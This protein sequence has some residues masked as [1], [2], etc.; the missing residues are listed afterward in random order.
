M[1]FAALLNLAYTARTALGV[2]P[3]LRAHV[4]GHHRRFAR[5]WA[6]M[7]GLAGRGLSDYRACREATAAAV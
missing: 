2:D 5:G 4:L 3:E 1:A 6:L 7:G